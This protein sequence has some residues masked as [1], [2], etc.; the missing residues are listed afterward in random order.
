[1]RD[2]VDS[3]EHIGVNS[4]IDL[5]NVVVGVSEDLDTVIGGGV[6]VVAAVPANEVNNVV[7]PVHD[8]NQSVVDARDEMEVDD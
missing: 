7:G 4:V 8:V 1:M 6:D 5:V 3:D 2:I